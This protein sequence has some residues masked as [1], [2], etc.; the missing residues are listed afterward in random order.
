MWGLCNVCHHICNIKIVFGVNIHNVVCMQIIMCE[1][2]IPFD[3]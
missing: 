1:R 3:M 2:E